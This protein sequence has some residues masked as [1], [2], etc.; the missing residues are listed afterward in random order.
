MTPE[1]QPVFTQNNQLI[2]EISNHNLKHGE[3]KFCFSLVYSIVSIEG[4]EIIKQ[5]GRYY[6]L[7]THQNNIYVTLQPSQIKSY[8]MSCG[9][10]G[11]FIITKNE[12]LLKLNL[13]SL[14]FEKEIISPS[15]NFKTIDNFNPIIPETEIANFENKFIN[16]QNQKIKI[17]SEDIKFFEIFS[18][19][20]SVISLDFNSFEGFPLIFKKIG[21]QEEEYKINVNENKI[22][23]FYNNYAGK[24]YAIISLIQLIHFYKNKL[25]LC[26]IEDKP[27]LKWR[28]MHLDCARQYY[29]INEIKRLFNYM[30]LFKLNRF[31]WHLTDNEAWRIK[32]DCYP[33]LTDAG[34]FRGYN[35]LIPPFYG[36]GY[37]KYGGYYD[38]DDVVELIQYGKKLNIEIMPELDLPAHS[39]TLL[40]VM[41]ELRDQSSNNESKDV[42][43]YSNNTI[44]P[45]VEETNIFLENVF[46][47]LS[48]IFT[49]DII[50]VGVDERPKDSWE[51]SPKII[52]FMKKNKLASYDEVQDLYMNNIISIL[53]KNNKRTAAWNEAALPPYNE[54]G[55]SGS[56]GALDKSCLVF[57]W[58]H[59]EVG[60]ESIK[61]KFETILCPGQ[62]TYFD[63]A[64][65]NSTEE[66][67]ICWAATIE[68]KEIHDWKPMEGIEEN[69]K[70]YVKGI[71]GQLWSETIT[72]KKYFD[73]MINPRLATLSEIAWRSKSYRNWI[74]FRSSLLNSVELLKK[75]GWK[76]HKF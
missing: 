26:N 57:A 50:H 61:R 28:G 4:A 49:F 29:S 56:A 43:L 11:V 25:P 32:L 51:S 55:S 75:M 74:E 71:Q 72:N 30:A 2:I 10:E 21:I 14:K 6:E 52:E 59:P 34:A 62:K 8:N 45:S 9:P 46:K 38:K 66:R 36:S 39:W 19:Y 40:Q 73:S 18:S 12:E 69:D 65:N 44:N 23:I 47:E 7:K 35:H 5:V 17:K 24:F 76:F 41:P 58:E 48:E 27:S 64:Y 60:I 67:G 33:N 31:H 22:E 68:V 3:F 15:Y 1:V 37:H 54:I 13:K 63:M 20:T 16:L 70:K 53:K 42:G